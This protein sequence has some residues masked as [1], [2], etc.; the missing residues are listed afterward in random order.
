MTTKVEEK[1][2]DDS[3]EDRSNAV[4]D[5]D[6]LTKGEGVSPSSVEVSG[7]GSGKLKDEDTKP[8][9]K[10]KKKKKSKLKEEQTDL[11]S[12]EILSDLARPRIFQGPEVDLQ[13]KIVKRLEKA[14]P[15]LDPEAEAT[16]N[17]LQEEI[18]AWDLEFNKVTE[19]T[20]KER[21]DHLQEFTRRNKMLPTD[22]YDQDLLYLGSIELT[23]LPT[24]KTD[25]ESL[26]DEARL[27][28]SDDHALRGDQN[29][30]L[31]PEVA[32][33]QQ[34]IVRNT[35]HTM[36]AAG[37]MDYLRASGF[38]GKG[39]KVVI[40]I[41]YYRSRAKTQANL[42]KDT[43]GQTMFVNL[44]Y[45]NDKPMPGPEFVVN[46]PLVSTHEKKLEENMPEQFM[47]DLEQ[48]RGMGRPRTIETGIMP[49]Y[50][51]VSFV[52]ETIHHAT[53]LLG[54]REVRIDKVRQF[55]KEDQDFS[56]FFTQA[57][58]AYNESVKKPKGLFK[59]FQKPKQ[60]LDLFDV[61][62]DGKEKDRWRALME[63]CSGQDDAKVDRPEL[64][65]LGLTG[66][67]V[68]RLLSGYGPDTFNSVN[69][70][71]KAHKDALPGR[72]PLTT[73][74]SGKPL[75]L[76]RQMSQLA[77]DKQLPEDPGGPRRFFRTWVRTV[78][79]ED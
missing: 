18:F 3:D 71:A 8:E 23:D 33:V 17:R 64:M 72:S 21:N 51:V 12:G 10:R 50:G 29:G 1:E 65:R 19:H 14:I 9:K 59:H 27:I 61:E 31:L 32:G 62:L 48:T 45:T 57:Q 69:I 52:D 4:L 22:T 37:Q 70:P 49:P 74:K 26:F 39:W 11:T 68:D 47:E 79:T 6:T 76:K 24:T 58:A 67:Q 43:L 2:K 60:F 28:S 77:L 73:G 7:L 13:Q 34:A 56:A 44:N 54:H 16:R 63:L 5:N 55:L 15:K 30:S 42:H 46:P 66:K 35:L 75:Q 36:I 20:E 53:P 41:H 38:V 40:E 25:E 78:R